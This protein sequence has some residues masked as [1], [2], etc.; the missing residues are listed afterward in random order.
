MDRKF[1]QLEKLSKEMMTGK[2]VL[3]FCGPSGTGKTTTLRALYCQ[4]RTVTKDQ[5]TE[6]LYVDAKHEDL[7]A[8]CTCMYAF[9]DNAQCLKKKPYSVHFLSGAKSLCLAFSPIVVTESGSST[10]CG[11]HYTRLYNFRPFS[12]DEFEKYVKQSK[13]IDEG[14]IS[15]MKTMNVLLP[16]MV[17][18]CQQTTQSVTRWVNR[19]IFH[20]LRKVESRLQSD[21]DKDYLRTVLMNAA[22]NIKDTPAST[23]CA[24]D[25]GIFYEDDGGVPQL[26]FPAEVLLQHL[27]R[28]IRCN[29]ALLE[30]YDKGAAHEFLVCAQLRTIAND[31]RCNGEKPT[32][33][34]K[35]FNT[36]HYTSGKQEFC[37]PPSDQYIVQNDYDDELKCEK[38]CCVVKLHQGHF[39]IDFLIIRNPGGA[40]SKRLFLIQ[41]SLTRYSQ[42]KGPKL[43]EIYFEKNSFGDKSCVDFYCEKTGVKVDQ[44]FFVYA[45][46]EVH[47]YAKFSRDAQVQNKVYF[48]EILL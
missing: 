20:Y 26:I 40:G 22:M 9:V 14:V 28:H 1:A 13:V 10:D 8:V 3:F 31:V 44:C 18:Q 43:E 30:Q 46:P 23:A 19:Q 37:I 39:G 16:R 12:K 21:G 38:Q 32:P 11:I 24:L 15:E 47:N 42:R 6:L 7:Q 41:A 27:H 35:T 29:Y 33:V 5:N 2:N 45:T 36:N 25:C 17:T 48:L 34:G 4:L